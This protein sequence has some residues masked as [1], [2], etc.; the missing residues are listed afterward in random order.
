[1]GNG[2][3]IPPKLK[4]RIAIWSSNP[5]AGYI[6]KR[7]GNR[8]WKRYLCAHVHSNIIPDRQE[9]EATQV[10][11]HRWMKNKIWYTHT[12][13][14]YSALKRKKNLPQYGWILRILSQVKEASNRK[15]NTVW[16]HLLETLRVLKFWKTENRITAARAQGECGVGSYCLVSTEFQFAKWEDF[17]W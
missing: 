2:K 16:C 8:A 5:T 13:K 11:T 7:I 10:S 3:E 6:S 14:Y 17:R 15:T 9:V 1:M 4:R 12:M